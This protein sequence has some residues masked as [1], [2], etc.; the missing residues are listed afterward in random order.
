MGV[1]ERE[2]A[3]AT[4]GPVL[5][6][7]QRLDVVLDH[8]GLVALGGVAPFLEGGVVGRW[9]VAVEGEALEPVAAPQAVPVQV[10]PTLALHEVVGDGD[11]LGPE[12]RYETGKSRKGR[13]P[14]R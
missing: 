11:G 14:R 1:G 7:S 10:G 5:Q 2:L 9:D 3:E 13:Q 8:R 12:L 6:A 4:G